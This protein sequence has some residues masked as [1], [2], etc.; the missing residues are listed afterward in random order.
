MKYSV[1]LLS[2][3]GHFDITSAICN[4]FLFGDQSHKKFRARDLR[5]DQIGGGEGGG[6]LAI[7]TVT[8]AELWR[9]V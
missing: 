8:F 5:C 1:S 9:G 6:G 7:P 3:F 4:A 2:K